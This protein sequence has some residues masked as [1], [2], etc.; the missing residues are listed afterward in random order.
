M[1]AVMLGLVSLARAQDELVLGKEISIEL[2]ANDDML[3]DHGPSHELVCRSPDDGTLFL[4]AS[5]RE[6]VDPFL[7]VEDGEGNVIA[8]DDNSGG[9]TAALRQQRVRAGDELWV[10]VA[11]G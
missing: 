7:H 2:T 4:W 10:T 3:E 9:G 6:R 1:T 8:E 5:S 11:L